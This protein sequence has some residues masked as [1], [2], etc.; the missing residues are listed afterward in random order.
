M[1]RVGTKLMTTTACHPQTNGQTERCNKTITG[2]LR[3]YIRERQDDWDTFVQPQTYVYNSQTHSTTNTTPFNL[4]LT[5][6]PPAAFE[7][8]RISALS[9]TQKESSTSQELR[10]V[11]LDR[12]SILWTKSIKA[13]VKVQRRYKTNFDEKV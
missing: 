5:R 6:E 2:R 4:I 7:I 13:T 11:L 3:H 9:S 8:L 1:R 12:I 10:S